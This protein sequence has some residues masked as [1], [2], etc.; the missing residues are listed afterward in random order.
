MATI[1][2][3][4]QP[5]K[6]FVAS[7]ESGRIRELATLVCVGALRLRKQGGQQ[8]ASSVDIARQVERA[9]AEVEQGIAQAVKIGWLIRRDDHVAL[10]A[11]GIYI[12]KQALNL[13]R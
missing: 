7:P 4:P 9:A 1:D 10:T 3:T 6:G 8:Q 11:A 5:P 12:A 2:G 13:P